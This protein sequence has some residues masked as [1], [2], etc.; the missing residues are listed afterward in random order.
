MSSNPDEYM[1]IK[2]LIKSRRTQ[3]ITN[4]GKDDECYFYV[5]WTEDG[6]FKF[7][8]SEDIKQRAS[9]SGFIDRYL[10]IHLIHTSTRLRIANLEAL[11]KLKLNI[12]TEYIEES[13]VFRFWEIFRD[14]R[15]YFE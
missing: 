14:L 7:G 12:C 8:A 11:I 6:Y 9:Y 10:S 2:S 5:T 1:W 4:G 15:K 13:E 3:F